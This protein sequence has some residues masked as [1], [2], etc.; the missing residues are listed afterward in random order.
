M[1]QVE[2]N[3]MVAFIAQSEEDNFHPQECAKLGFASGRANEGNDVDSLML[4]LDHLK[5][6]LMLLIQFFARLQQQVAKLQVNLI[7]SIQFHNIFRISLM[8]MAV[9]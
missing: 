2:A 4:T 6:P 9:K 7:E 5:L 1:K 3:Q 8:K